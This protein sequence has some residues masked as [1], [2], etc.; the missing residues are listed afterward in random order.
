MRQATAQLRTKGENRRQQ[1]QATEI[2]ALYARNNGREICGGGYI[3]AAC[4][5]LALHTGFV[6]WSRHSKPSSQ[7]SAMQS[8][9][10]HVADLA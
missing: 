6:I 7:S 8:L 1:F 9:D 2:G 10:T 3:G 4:C 5:E